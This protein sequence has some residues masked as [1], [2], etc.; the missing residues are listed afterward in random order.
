MD[1]EQIIRL[2][3]KVSESNVTR[4]SVEEGSLKIDIEKKEKEIIHSVTGLSGVEMPA[5]IPA[6][7]VSPVSNAAEPLDFNDDDNAQYI[8]APIVGMFYTAPSPDSKPYVQVGDTVKK[9]QIVGIVEAMKLMNEI[10][11]EVSGTVVEV[12]VANGSAV[13]YGQ[14]LFKV[15]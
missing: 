4:F 10:E 15:R 6:V 7:Q 13:E 2:I 3:D 14:K 5:Q 9:G 1:I 12:L 8:T 11:S